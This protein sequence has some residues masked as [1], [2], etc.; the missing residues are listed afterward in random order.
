MKKIDVLI[1]G[2]GPIGLACGI[3]A[4]KNELDYI[5]LEKGTL[6]NSI[7]NYPVN[8]TFFSTSEK[9]EMG[10]IP[11]MS[12]NKQPTRPEALEYYRRIAKHFDLNINLYEGVKSVERQADGAFLVYSE[13]ET[14]FAEKVVLSTGFYDIPNKLNVPGEDL[15]KVTHYYKEP[16]PYIGQKVI[17]VGGGN[18]GVD[19]ALETWR[20]GAEVTMVLKEP[21]VDQNVKYWVLPDIEN[22]IK[23][24]SIG[25]YFSSSIKEIREQE[26]VIDTP[27]GEKTL[28]NDFVLAMTGYRPNFELLD[29]LGVGLTLDEKRRPCFD[30][31]Q[32]SNVP[33]LY[34][35][36][37]VCGGLN[38][39]EFFIE[40]TIVHA[41][42][43][44]TDIMNKRKQL[45]K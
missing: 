45:V 22:R 6:V 18:S 44:F 11:F 19:V 10:G 1:V 32:E 31:N 12:V 21:T 20:K 36:G 37:V 28:E 24:G 7:Y 14:Y 16:W 38:T 29:Q 34:L 2:A 26:V 17:V 13:K 15:A 9:L 35:A 40:N 8:M 33:G 23:E 3:E 30:G 43:I 25:A 27:Q 41:Q 4:E 5:I 42:A 39:R